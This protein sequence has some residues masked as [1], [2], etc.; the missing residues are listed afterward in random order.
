MIPYVCLIFF[1]KMMYRPT[2][3]IA[4]VTGN[5]KLFRDDVCAFIKAHIDTLPPDVRWTA[6]IDLDINVFKWEAFVVVRYGDDEEECCSFK[7][8]IYP[9]GFVNTRVEFPFMSYQ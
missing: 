1:Q 2:S 7:G 9:N 4:P 8:V 6:D 5:P 3:C